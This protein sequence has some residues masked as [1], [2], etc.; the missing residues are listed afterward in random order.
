MVG[1][2]PEIFSGWKSNATVKRDW[3]QLKF[4]VFIRKIWEQQSF[5][6]GSANS[7]DCGSWRS[8]T[9]I[10]FHGWLVPHR[11]LMGSVNRLPCALRRAMCPAS[12][13]AVPRKRCTTPFFAPAPSCRASQRKTRL[14]CT[15]TGQVA[16]LAWRVQNV[17]NYNFCQ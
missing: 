17:V 6:S 5:R 1:Y 16:V 7:G 14:A 12:G 11:D 8:G 4:F 10:R 2:T 13:D 9:K 15:P 3:E